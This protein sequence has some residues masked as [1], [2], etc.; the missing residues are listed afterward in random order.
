[1]KAVSM[2][3]LKVFIKTQTKR[4]NKANFKSIAFMFQL[5]RSFS[6]IMSVTFF[7]FHKT[8]QNVQNENRNEI[9]E[10]NALLKKKIKSTKC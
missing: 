10:I 6:S 7:A 9:F 2:L 3:K 1:M 8:K 4:K 5:N